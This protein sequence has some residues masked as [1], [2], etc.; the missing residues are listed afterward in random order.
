ME[1]VIQRR[2]VSENFLDDCAKPETLVVF[3]FIIMQFKELQEAFNHIMAQL[4]DREEERLYKL[5]FYEAII[6]KVC[7]MSGVKTVR[8]FA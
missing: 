5:A 6:I 8:F 2:S 3:L 1:V 7:M 4:N